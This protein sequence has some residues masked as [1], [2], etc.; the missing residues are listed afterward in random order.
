MKIL[1]IQTIEVER[2]ICEICGEQLKQNGDGVFLQ[3]RSN[4]DYTYTLHTLC[5]IDFLNKFLV[6]DIK[7]IKK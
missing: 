7:S 3:K 5:L 2:F 6:K 4:E 1:T